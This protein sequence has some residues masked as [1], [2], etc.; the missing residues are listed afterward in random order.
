MR[1]GEPIPCRQVH[2]IIIKE[3]TLTPGDQRN[4]TTI[5][6]NE[7]GRGVVAEAG[8]GATPPSQTAE[9]ARDLLSVKKL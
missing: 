6:V 5:A 8:K 4:T 3:D 9:K 7:R 2:F 1:T